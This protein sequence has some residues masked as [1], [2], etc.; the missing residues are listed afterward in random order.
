MTL[1]HRYDWLLR[2]SPPR[3][4]GEAIKLYGIVETPGPGSTRSIIDWAKETGLAAVYSTDSIPWCG[5]FMAVVVRRSGR[6]AVDSP[7]WARSWRSW[8]VPSQKPSLGDVLV[9][10]RG[11]GG[12]VALYIAEDNSTYHVLGGNQS[13]SVSIMRILKDRLLSARMP[14]YVNRP[15]SARSYWLDEGGAMSHDER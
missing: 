7:L 6:S 12:H 13:D 4:V 11:S 9:F 14:R 15:P 5:L 8:Q 2:V 3:V 1:P 10:E